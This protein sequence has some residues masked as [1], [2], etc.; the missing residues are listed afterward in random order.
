[1]DKAR[2]EIVDRVT[3]RLDKLGRDWSKLAKDLNESPQRINN[4]KNARGIPHAAYGR[5]A[6][7]LGWTVDEL[8][9]ARTPTVL[10]WPFEKIPPFRLSRLSPGQLMQAEGHL[11]E[12]LEELE[13]ASRKKNLDRKRSQIRESSA[14]ATTVKPRKAAHAARS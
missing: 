9:G 2:Q 12:K 14:T 13:G 4:W 11:L 7:Y 1:M 10:G 3:A 6:E 8:L 5:V